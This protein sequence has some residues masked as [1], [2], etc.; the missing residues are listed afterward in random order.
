MPPALNDPQVLTDSDDEE[1]KN[2]EG[3]SAP[4]ETTQTKDA[5]I[6]VR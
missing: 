5:S 1:D 2:D 6:L 4:V 3:P